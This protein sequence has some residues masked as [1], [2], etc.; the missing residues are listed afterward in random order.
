MRAVGRADFHQARRLGH[1]LR[2]PEGAADFDELAARNDDFLVRGQRRQ[3]EHGGGGVV[4]DHRGGFGAGQSVRMYSTSSSRSAR[5][6]DSRP[7][8][9][10]N[11]P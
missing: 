7:P 9:A 4:V 5:S 3:H 6:P 2:Q 11:S 10:C 1:D 8:P